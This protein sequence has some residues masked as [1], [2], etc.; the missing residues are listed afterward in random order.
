MKTITPSANTTSANLPSLREG[1]TDVITPPT[2]TDKPP[3]PVEPDRETEPS[4]DEPSK[5]SVSPPIPPAEREKQNNGLAHGGVAPETESRPT[6]PTAPLNPDP[7]STVAPTPLV[8]VIESKEHAE[9]IGVDAA[10]AKLVE[11]AMPTADAKT[12]AKAANAAAKAAAKRSRNLRIRFDLSF[13]KEFLARAAKRRHFEGVSE[14][15]AKG[16]VKTII[17]NKSEEEFLEFICP[18]RPRSNSE[19]APKITPDVT[20]SAPPTNP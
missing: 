8:P 12:A 10:G 17:V 6:A 15:W 9:M 11:E 7:E 4:S 14:E 3:A 16:M 19:A 18:A 13:S 20:P 1:V 2:A 5:E